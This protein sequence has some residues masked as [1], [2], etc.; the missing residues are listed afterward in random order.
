MEKFKLFHQALIVV[1]LVVSL[2][3]GWYFSGKLPVKNAYMP[4]TVSIKFWYPP[5]LRVSVKNGLPPPPECRNLFKAAGTN[6]AKGASRAAG[7]I[8]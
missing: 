4:L 3:G 7:G 8:A 5:P 2:G 1:F 6:C